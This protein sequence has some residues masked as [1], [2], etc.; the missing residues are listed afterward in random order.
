MLRHRRP[1]TLRELLEETFGPILRV[2]TYKNVLYLILAFPLGFIYGTALGFGLFFGIG[3]SV[4]LVG[5]GILLVCVLVVRLLSGFERWLSNRLLGVELATP[6]AGATGDGVGGTVRAS[7]EA[8][9]TWRGLGFLSLKFWFGIVGLLLLFG[10]STAYS[11]ITAPI[12]R[13]RRIE[14]GE[15]NGEPVVWTVETVPEAAAAGLIGVV[16]AV[17]LL[18]LSNLFGYVARRVSISLLGG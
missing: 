18:H 16:I 7:L 9:S 5:L 14:F 8:N 15:L 1:T 17:V 4:V 10:F 13:P 11:M 12:G 3:L 2:Q 6:E